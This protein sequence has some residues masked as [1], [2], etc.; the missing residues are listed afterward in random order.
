MA[1]FISRVRKYRKTN[2]LSQRELAFLLG[3]S[4]QG[5]LSELEGG[6]RH[7]GIRFAIGC[8]ILFGVPLPEIFPYLHDQTAAEILGKAEELH[9][10]LSGRRTRA[11]TAAY[12]AAFISRVRGDSDAT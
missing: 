7:P 11:A 12:L 8:A 4:S 2:S 10:K 9:E 6:T 5:V 1:T 3:L